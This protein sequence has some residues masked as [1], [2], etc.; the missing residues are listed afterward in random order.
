M[1]NRELS[2]SRRSPSKPR[3]KTPQAPL[4]LP[5]LIS[6]MARSMPEAEAGQSSEADLS[7]V[8]RFQPASG[9]NRDKALTPLQLEPSAAVKKAKDKERGYQCPMSP[10]ERVARRHR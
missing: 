2:D 5:K 9:Y 7:P 1:G 8:S 6:W 3:I 10:C 4:A